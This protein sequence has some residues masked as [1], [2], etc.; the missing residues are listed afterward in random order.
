MD[1]R[2]EIGTVVEPYERGRLDLLG[3]VALGALAVGALGSVAFT[4]RAGHRN[5][6]LLLIAL[7]VVWVLSPFVALV[8]S[9]TISRRWVHALRVWLICLTMAVALGSLAIYGRI[10]LGPP[11]PQAAAPFL[12]VPA[13]SWVFI[14]I[15][16]M[17]AR[18]PAGQRGTS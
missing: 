11:R 2:N 12:F 9:Q 14:G 13:I 15:T 3:K 8:W 5:K 6:S 7:F 16:L 18:R 1:R 10:T 4:L 17:W